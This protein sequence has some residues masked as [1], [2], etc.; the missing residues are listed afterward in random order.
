[1]LKEFP[2]MGKPTVKKNVKAIILEHYCIFYKVK[3]NKIF[4]LAF[5]DTRQ[6]PK[7]LLQF[8]KQD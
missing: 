4:I 7:L 8:L 6:N 2:E 1:M 3:I 5:W